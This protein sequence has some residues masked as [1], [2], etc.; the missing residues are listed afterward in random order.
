[1]SKYKLQTHTKEENGWLKWQNK[2]E[3]IEFLKANPRKEFFT[4]LERVTEGRTYAQNSAIHL[5][6]EWVARELINK[7]YT[8]Q[9]VIAQI[10]KAEIT[11]TK[12]N[13]KEV[14]WRPMQMAVL[15][16]ESTKDLSK[17]EID[18]VYQPLSMFLAKNFEIDLPF[19][20]DDEKQLNKLTL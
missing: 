12:D 10:K 8:L 19:P 1:M 9:N 2:R 14:L 11:P 15:N 6:L 4:T 5:Y 17:F 3:I 16:K 7:G 20:S 18:S 13:L